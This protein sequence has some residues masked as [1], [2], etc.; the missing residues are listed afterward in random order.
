METP[1]KVENKK[2]GNFKLE[3]LASIPMFYFP[4]LNHEKDKLAFY[5]DKTG[6]NELY[7]MNLETKS[8]DQITDGDLPRALRADYVWSRDDSKIIFTKDFEGDERH[9]L[10]EIDLASK[11][12]TQLTK[13]PDFQEFIVDSS[14]DGKWYTVVA[15]RHGQHN[16]YRMENGN[17]DNFEQITAHENPAM[18]GSYSDDGEWITY[19]SNEEADLKN[20]DIYLAKPDGS[21][22]ER[23]VQMKVGSQDGFA[24][25]HPDSK[26]FAFSSDRTGTSQ[27]GIYNIETKETRFFGDN[28]NEEYAGRFSSN[29]KYLVCMLNKDASVSPVVYDVDTGERMKFDFPEGIAAGTIIKDNRYLFLTVNTPKS[30]SQLI[31]FDI[32]TSES[33]VLL[34]TDYGNVDSS[35]LTDS[36]HIFYPSLDGTPIPAIVTKP[37]DWS[38]DKLYPAIM[39]PHGGPTGQY[40]MNFG[41]ISQ[42][43]ADLGYVVMAPNVRG[44]TGYGVEFRDACIRAWGTLDH[45]DWV[46]GRQWMIDNA[47]VDPDRVAVFGGSYGGYATLVCVTKSPDL[48]AAGCAWIP[49]SHLK[50]MY[51]LSNDMFKWFLRMQMGDPVK[52]AELWEQSSPLNYAENI[53]A[54]LMLVHGKNDPRCPVEESRNM[55][56][57]LKELGKTEGADGDFE[58]VE[59]QDEGHG[60]FSDIQMRIRSLKLIADFMHRRI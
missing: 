55:V 52:D 50:N 35:L 14:P 24:A 53:T 37:R 7:I 26:S 41:F 8:I 42:Y 11:S 56:S 44:S 5:W 17:P 43:F 15:N 30:P 25:W 46:A 29:G 19:G 57:R 32:E 49:V 16:V 4:K 47:A 48:W 34:D 23:V 60:G 18:G 31:K 9:D 21:L 33:E 54:P 22:I 3:E 6:R 38:P 10:Y 40:F 13:T 2:E 1:V 51:E 28:S 27:A 39:H 45:D 58:Y 12:V 20:Q 36:D 59:Y